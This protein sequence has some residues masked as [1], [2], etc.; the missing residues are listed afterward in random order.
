MQKPAQLRLVS[1]PETAAL[2]DFE[3]FWEIYPRKR[4]KLD[5]RRAWYQVRADRPDIETM[6]AT[7]Q[8]RI[9]SGEWSDE[10]Y[11]PYPAS[12]LRA[13]GWSDE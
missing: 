1:D 10:R 13:G 12:F 7:I 8:E 5:A 4:N 2:S 11:I 3:L 9:H 6:L